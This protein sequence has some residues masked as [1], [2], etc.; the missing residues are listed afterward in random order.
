MCVCLRIKVL[1][2]GFCVFSRAAN[3]DIRGEG[4][5]D[6]AP[7]EAEVKLAIASNRR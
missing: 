5:H 1:L 7:E 2:G 3:P 4:R 6:R